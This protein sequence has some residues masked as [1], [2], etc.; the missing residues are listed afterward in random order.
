MAYLDIFEDDPLAPLITAEAEAPL[1]Q[2]T[3]QSPIVETQQDPNALKMAS[4]Y[5]TQRV[6]NKGVDG[7][8][9]AGFKKGAEMFAQKALVG[10]AGTAAAPAVASPLATAGSAFVTPGASLGATTAASSATAAPFLATAAPYIAAGL[11]AGKAFGL[12][13]KGG[14]VGAHIGGMIN[15]AGPLSGIRYKSQGGDVK[16]EVEV[17]YNAPLGG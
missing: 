9:D 12:F 2:T 16:E 1:A 5:A 15:M 7:T 10:T 8:V 6:V 17:K 11:V 14:P 13:N 4:D 3:K